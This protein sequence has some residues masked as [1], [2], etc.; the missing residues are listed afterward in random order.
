MGLFLTIVIGAMVVAIIGAI[1]NATQ[2][3]N[4]RKFLSAGRDDAEVF[5]GDDG[6]Y[7][8]LDFDR[9]T[10]GLGS[11]TGIGEASFADIL[12]VE[13]VENGTVITQTNR[14]S[15]AIG[16][17]VGSLAFGGIGFLAGSLTASTRSQN[18]IDSIILRIHVASRHLPSQDVLILGSS[19]KTGHEETGLWPR[20]GSREQ[21]VSTRSFYKR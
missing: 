19:G 8:M 10:I 5:V 20:L 4:R 11:L 2:N 6:S 17:A 16:A 7:L 18:N 9:H 13:V 21:T 14:G 1:L 15:Q 3:S 12:A